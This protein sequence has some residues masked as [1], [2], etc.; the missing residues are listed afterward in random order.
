MKLEHT[1]SCEQCNFKTSNKMHLKMHVKA[2]HKKNELNKVKLSKKR[3]SMEDNPSS[4]KKTKHNRLP[5]K[6]L[7]KE[8][9]VNFVM[10]KN[11]VCE[12]RLV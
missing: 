1:H 2:C 3:K 5:K 6:V 11:L 8:S 12:N 9:N 7:K 10:T 4:R